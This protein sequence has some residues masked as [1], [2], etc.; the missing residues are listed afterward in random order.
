MIDQ[1]TFGKVGRLNPEGPN[2][3]L[4]ATRTENRLW[5]AGNVAANLAAMWVK[6]TLIGTLGSDTEANI[7][8]DLIKK[9][10]IE[11]LEVLTEQP[12]ISKKRFVEE[13]YNTQML[14]VDT[15]EKIVLS[16]EQEDKIISQIETIAPDYLVVSDYAKWTLS[17][18]LIKKINTV[19]KPY[20]LDTKPVR[21]ALYENLFLL[22]PNFKEFKDMIKKDIQNTDE[23]IELYGK[24]LSQNL[25]ANIV[26]TR[27]E[28]GAT[29]ITKEW[30]CLHIDTEAEQVF[31]VSWAWDTFLA[32]LVAW[33]DRNQSL[34]EAVRVANKASAIAVKRVWTAV[35]S[36]DQLFP[37]KNL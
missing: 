20:F 27:W 5:W 9:Y 32:G 19:D 33:L 15:E 16:S 12:T 10:D 6:T 4:T 30:F 18:S 17:D 28:R 35:V 37:G 34:E 2:P 7:L 26:I 29:L 8:R 24:D 1:Y 14:R 22:K 31:D 25:K 13:T 23:Q 11:L 3:L 36:Q 21:L